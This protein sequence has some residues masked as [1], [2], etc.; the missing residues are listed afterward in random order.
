MEAEV[1]SSVVGIAEEVV[2]SGASWGKAE[3]VAEVMVVV[4]RVVAEKEWGVLEGIRVVEAGRQG[5]LTEQ[6]AA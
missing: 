5:N 4:V 6:Q 2:P 1:E 3:R